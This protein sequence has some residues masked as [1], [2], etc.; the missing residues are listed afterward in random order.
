[1]NKYIT[2]L[3]ILDQIRHEAPSSYRRYY[4]IESN[5]EHLNNARSR[6]FIHLFLKVKFGL[7]DFLERENLLLDDS[8][9]GGIDAYF[10]DKDEKIIYFIQ[11]KFRSNENNFISREIEFREILKMDC[12][13]ITHGEIVDELGNPYNDKVIRLIREIQSIDDIGRYNYKIIILANIRDVSQSQLSRL[14]GGFPA[15]V[16]NHEKCYSELVFPIIKGVHFSATDLKIFINLSNVLSSS[17]INYLVNTEYGN[18]KIN[19][20]YV[21]SLEIAKILYKY[22]NAILIYNPRSYLSISGNEVNKEISKTILEKQT[23]EFALFNNGITM[24]SEDTQFN[25]NV[26]RPDRAQLIINNPQIINGAQTA[27]TLSKIYEDELKKQSGFSIFENKEVLL[28]VI[29]FINDLDN[30]VNENEK[31]KLIEEISKATNQQTVVTVADRR[32]NDEN[33]INLQD[34][35]FQDFGYF[36]ERK[37]GEF[38]NG[39]ANH[40]VD[41]NLVINRESF[42]R[43]CYA[44]NNK[45]SQARRNSEVVLFRDNFFNYLFEDFN[46][47]KEYFFGYKCFELLSKI[48]KIYN[49]VPNNKFGIINYGNALRYGKLAVTSICAKK[50]N[51]SFE[52]NKYDDYAGEIVKNILQQWLKFEKSIIEKR[53]NRKYFVKTVDRDTGKESLETNYDGYYKGSTLDQDLSEF[54]FI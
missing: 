45:S 9:D 41:K 39:L 16:Y 42:I 29:T 32:S 19:V 33:L 1:M 53:T 50:F 23:N 5:I 43:V 6:A 48:E 4:P 36:F 51:Q 30:I 54:Y 24:L 12:Q 3:K 46:R 47:Y 27:Y 40:Y 21:P 49:R 15:E 8:G 7:L 13:R 17:R 28:K 18:C 35:I 52:M 10:I 26:G 34:K 22:K 44:C 14:I 11:S 25:E 20:I 2:L 37:R 38:Y 31:V